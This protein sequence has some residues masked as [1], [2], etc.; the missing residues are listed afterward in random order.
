MGKGALAVRGK[1][2]RQEDSQIGESCLRV[3]ASLFSEWGSGQR[4]GWLGSLGGQRSL[5]KWRSSGLMG[6]EA[7][8]ETDPQEAWV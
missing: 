2:L 8:M 7:G 3:E 5:S 4:G 1:N 6:R